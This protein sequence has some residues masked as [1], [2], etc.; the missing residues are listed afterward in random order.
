MRLLIIEDRRRIANLTA[1]GLEPLGFRC[2]CAASL[3][4]ADEFLDIADYDALV[5]DQGLPDGDGGEWLRNRRACGLSKPVII[6][7]ARA[8]IEDRILGLDAGADDYLVKP[9]VIEELAARLRAILRR[10]GSRSA[11]I[12]SLGGIR[13]DPRTRTGSCNGT[14][15]GLTKRE[16]D[17]LELMI[18]RAGTVV[19]RGQ[20]ESS[21]YAF[22][23][24]ITPNAIEALISRLRKKLRAAGDDS[25]VTLRGIGHLLVDDSL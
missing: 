2:D 6:L 11:A 22:A 12:L 7:T 14:A 3:S 23:Q 5:L 8:A 25:F 1:A 24:D 19:T 15:L 21:L 20:I 17:L 16:A 10:P 4:R 18:R 9:F 13:F